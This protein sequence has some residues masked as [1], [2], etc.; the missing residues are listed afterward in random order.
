MNYLGATTI[1]GIIFFALNVTSTLLF[2]V[3]A[4]VF[5]ALLEAV[6]K[7]TIFTVVFHYIH[8]FVARKLS[9]YDEK[10]SPASDKAS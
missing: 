2:S 5:A 6:V 4:T 1:A 7:T 8:N 3:N 9:L 10:P